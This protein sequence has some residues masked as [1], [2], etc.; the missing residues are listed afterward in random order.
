[1][2]IRPLPYGFKTDYHYY[3]QNILSGKGFSY[4]D[5]GVDY[6]DVYRVPGYSL[7]LALVY[8]IFGNHYFPVM[9]IQVFLNA[10]VCVFIF[11]ITKRYFS[12]KFSYAISFAVAIYPFTA[13]FVPTIYA[14]TLCIFLFSLG[15][16][17]FEKARASENLLLFS[18]SGIT[19]GYC[20]LVRPGTA[21]FPFFITIAYLFVANLRKIW[22]YLLVFNF[23]V[24]LIWAPWVVRN[25]L[26][27]G[28]FI[29]LTI[30]GNE[31]LFWSTGAI[32]KYFETRMSNPKFIGEL[33]EVKQKLDASGLSG[34]Q[35]TIEY[36]AFFFEYAVKNIK[37]NPFLYLFATI[38]RIPR[39][40]ISSPVAD[41]VSHNYGYEIMKSRRVERRILFS[42][43]KYFLTGCLILAVYGIWLLRRR[44]R[45]FIF[46]LL[47]I[48]YF[49]LTHMFLLAEARYTLPARPYL[50]VF[51]IIGV[52]AIVKK[53]FPRLNITI[54]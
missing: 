45:E 32:G 17:L 43:I 34:L 30:E 51:T 13:V 24:V 40:W 42:L 37:D 14:E 21:L 26:V 18:F 36:E 50:I 23:C 38:R 35:K 5:A 15:L 8:K 44:W 2:I 11:Y 54:F 10:A 12:L 28:K 29:P 46:L 9:L 49:S 25:Y 27:T 53:F 52:V 7:F 48:I 33:V 1:M 20:L 4:S 16:F 3:A 6:L 31:M 22:K 41:D 39:M 19:F 47:P